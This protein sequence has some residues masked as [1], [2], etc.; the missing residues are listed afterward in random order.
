MTTIDN[1]VR[2]GVDTATLFATLDAVKG[3]TDLAKFQFRATNRWLSGTHNQSTIHGYHGAKQ[4][5]TH[6]SRSP[7]TPT[8]RRC[9]SGRT[10]AD[11][12]RVPAARPRRVP[13][14]G[15]RQHRRARGVNLTEVSST[16]EGDIDL[17]G[18]LGLSDQVRNGYQQ[19]KVS[20]WSG[21]TTRRSCAPSSSSRVAGRPYSTSSPTACPSRST[22][23]P[24]DRIARHQPSAPAQETTMRTDNR[25]NPTYD[26]VIVG[27]RV[28]GAATAHL[29]A[30]FGLQVLLVDRGHYGTD[31][32]STH[33]LMRGG[34]LQLS[35]WGLLDQIISAGTP[36]IRRT[37]FGYADAVV[38]IAIKSSYGVDALYA[39][40]VPSSIR[41]SSTRPP[42]PA[43]TCDSASPSTDVERDRHGTVIGI[44]GR[45]RRRPAA[46]FGPG[47]S[48]A[49]TGSAPPSPSGSTRTSNASGPRSPPSHTAT[50]RV[51]RTTATNGTSAPMPLRGRPDERRPGLRVRQRLAPPHRPRRHRTPQPRS[52]QNRLQTSPPGFAAATP[53]AALRTF[54]GRPGHIRRSW[55]RG[56]ALVGDAATSR[57]R[58]PRTE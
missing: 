51:W 17:L 27:A 35:R 57:I 23:T 21:A 58:S 26:V 3:D 25:N 40:G 49:R 2:N 54:T 34:V 32:L 37:T 6:R 18:I 12:G 38:P 4:E 15:H 10:T 20:F 33:A 5:L 56:W 14:R 41:S 46:P 19:I 29:L 16:V 45:T 39:P 48:S 1:A 53:P 7:S 43:S 44:V 31:T 8:T 11:A 42:Q 22:S 24:A 47:S 52:S 30:R 9:W 28:A 13:H 36:A 50:G 55:G